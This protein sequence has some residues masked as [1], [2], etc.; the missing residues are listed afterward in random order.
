[1]NLW[2]ASISSAN[3]SGATGLPSQSEFLAQFERTTEGIIVYKAI[4]N[5]SYTLPARWKIEPNSYLEEV[6]NPDRCTLC[7]CGVNVASLKWCK[8]NYE[9]AEYWR[10]LIPWENC[11][12]VVVPYNTD[13]KF[14]VGKLKLIERV[15]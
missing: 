12:D 5:T 15:V 6:V 10:C 11:F 2:R 8:Q 14:R 4:G 3:L 9:K 1:V 7:G 13:G